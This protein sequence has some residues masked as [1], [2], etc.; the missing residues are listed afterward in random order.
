MVMDMLK[1]KVRVDRLGEL[2]LEMRMEIETT[3]Q[4]TVASVEGDMVV[5]DIGKVTEMTTAMAETRFVS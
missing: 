5:G 2:E 3:G 1:G 4:E